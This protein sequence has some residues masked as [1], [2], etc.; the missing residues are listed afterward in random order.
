MTR[1]AKSSG[2]NDPQFND[3]Y[4]LARF[5]TAQAGIYDQ[6]L[7]EIR[8]GQKQSHWM[9][10]IFPQL[11]GLGFSSMSRKYAIK[12]LD[13]ARTFLAHPVLGPRLMECAEGA[14]NVQDKSA[15]EIFDEPDDIKLRS[16]ATLFAQ[17]L[18]AG[19]V[20]HRLLEKYFG[21]RPDRKTL[22]LLAASRDGVE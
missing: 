14:L 6:A 4:D 16:S 20:F 12:S 15:S 10:F 11:A 7:A 21:G 13:E 17:V 8:A 1:L 22:E 19:S 9:W 5:E 2:A 18:P 3:P